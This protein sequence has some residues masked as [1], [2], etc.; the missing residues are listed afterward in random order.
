[1][2]LLT[3]NL[4]HRAARRAIPHWV[5]AA[6]GNQQPDLVVLTE[7]VE[8]D[9]HG[10]FVDA[11]AQQGLL[12]A[13]VSKRTAGHN[14]IL[15]ASKTPLLHGHINGPALHPAV[16][17]NT[18]H[19]VAKDLGC[20]VIGFRMPAFES[21]DWAIKRAVWEWL[22][23]ASRSLE[24]NPT[25]VTGDLNTAQ[26]DSAKFCGDCLS[27]LAQHGWQHAIPAEGFSWRSARHGTVRRIDQTFLSPGMPPASGR[28]LWDFESIAPDASSGRVGIP[29]HA[30]LIVDF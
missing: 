20:Q 1:M 8:S 13:Q 10:A 14:Q 6:I 17:S 4:N 27:V 9:A 23:Q 21:K 7:Y 22:I 19:V 2:R 25:V 15:I 11:L 3:W 28:Y 5:S 29:D 24:H 12:H 16:P 18:L 30:M 26:G